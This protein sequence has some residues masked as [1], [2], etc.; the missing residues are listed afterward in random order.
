MTDSTRA[1][2]HSIGLLLTEGCAVEIG[3]LTIAKLERPFFRYKWQVHCE[4]YAEQYSEL[5]DDMTQAISRFI[6]TKK[7]L[8]DSNNTRRK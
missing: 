8:Y 4:D 5:F 2:F 6:L 1:L 3:R 7:R